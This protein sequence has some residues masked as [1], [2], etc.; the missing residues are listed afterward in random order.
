MS[1]HHIEVHLLQITENLITDSPGIFLDIF[2]FVE[3]PLF[4][5]F[6]YRV[7]FEP[8]SRGTNFESID[9]FVFAL[10]I[11]EEW[12]KSSFQFV[13]GSISSR[14]AITTALLLTST[15]NQ[16]CNHWISIYSHWLH[17]FY[18]CNWLYC[19]FMICWM[20][21][22]L[23]WQKNCIRSLTEGSERQICTDRDY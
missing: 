12:W 14:N 13:T 20:L 7:D 1:W 21:Y 23:L 6:Y 11:K 15:M 2:W 4:V 5:D 18:L 17:S 10:F 16:H 8:K 9:C 22:W 19:M 3:V